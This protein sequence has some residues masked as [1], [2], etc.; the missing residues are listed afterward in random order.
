[1]LSEG[2]SLLGKVFLGRPLK[3]LLL[4]KSFLN[5]D[6]HPRSHVTMTKAWPVDLDVATSTPILWVPAPP[7][8][9][10]CTE[11]A[12]EERQTAGHERPPIC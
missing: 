9:S 6:Y 3:L 2:E 5:S 4:V 10:L 11:Y 1:M 7:S 12:N 8:T